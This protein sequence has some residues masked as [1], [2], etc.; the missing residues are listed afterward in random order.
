[1]VSTSLSKLLR[2]HE[3]DLTAVRT[4]LSSDLLS[5][6]DLETGFKEIA[7][8]LPERGK[9]A[10]EIAEFEENLRLVLQQRSA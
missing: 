5:A 9:S 8:K 1:M 7:P 4:L 3:G 2:G 10:T 6:E